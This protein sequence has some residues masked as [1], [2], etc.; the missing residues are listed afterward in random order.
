M[1]IFYYFYYIECRIASG[2]IRW[3]GLTTEKER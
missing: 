1:I 3:V 2:G